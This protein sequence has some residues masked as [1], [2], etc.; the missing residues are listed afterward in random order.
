MTAIVDGAA[1]MWASVGPSVTEDS[2]DAV[3]VMHDMEMGDTPYCPAHLVPN[4]VALPSV[5][6]LAVLTL[7]WPDYWLHSSPIAAWAVDLDQS[8]AEGVATVRY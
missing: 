7:R 6:G 2:W 3:G 8:T 1:A 5:Q 4:L